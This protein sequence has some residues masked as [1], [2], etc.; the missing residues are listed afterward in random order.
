LGFLTVILS[1]AAFTVSYGYVVVRAR[2]AGFDRS[3]EEAALDLGARP[4]QVFW[5][6]TLPLILPAVMAAGLLV[7]ALS[8]DDYVGPSPVAGVGATPLRLQS[9]SMVKSALSPEINA[10]STV[11]LLSTALLV[12]GAFLIEQGKSARLAALPAGLGLAVLLLPFALG[13]AP[14]APARTR[15]RS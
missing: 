1:H 4:L 7:F 2:I 10:V 8:I 6:V 3:L 5:K 13:G 14:L 9:Y 11:L 12:L 15:H